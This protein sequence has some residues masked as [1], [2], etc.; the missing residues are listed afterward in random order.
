MVHCRERYVDVYVCV[1]V[2]AQNACFFVSVVVR[3]F[4]RIRSTAY[5]MITFQHRSHDLHV[6][7]DPVPVALNY[8]KEKRVA[9][10]VIG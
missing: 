9:L 8:S 5:A 10:W 6:H 1:S 4:Y 2:C 7:S 3:I